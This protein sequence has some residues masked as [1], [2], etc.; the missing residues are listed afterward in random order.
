MQ[1]HLPPNRQLCGSYLDITVIDNQ[2]IIDPIVTVNVNYTHNVKKK[3]L[4][5]QHNY[6]RTS[7]RVDLEF[8]TTT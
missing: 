1:D 8:S 6:N 4:V 5:K 3:L 2:L 7:I